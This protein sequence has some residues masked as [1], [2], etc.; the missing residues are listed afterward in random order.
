MRPKFV[1]ALFLSVLVAL[2]MLFFLKRALTKPELSADSGPKKV[3]STI[4]TSQAASLAKRARIPVVSNPMTPEEHQAAVDAEVERLQDLSANNDAASL[5][6]ILNDL[7]S[8]DKTVR[9]AAIEAAKQ[10]GSADAIPTLKADAATAQ[11]PEEQTAMLEAAD[12]LS[13]PDM[14]LGGSDNGTPA[15]PEQI[16]ATQQKYAAMQ[17]RR[18]SQLQA[19]S[20]SNQGPQVQPQSPGN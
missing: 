15:T 16:Q 14:T 18:Q 2:G 9:L 12:I 8:P 7:T 13:L 19:H 3:V 6:A 11:D 17:A 20:D 10:F 5:T 1:F 4:V